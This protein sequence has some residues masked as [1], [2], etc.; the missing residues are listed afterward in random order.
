MRRG[1]A[2]YGLR[3]WPR[4]ATTVWTISPELVL[5]LDEHLG[6]PVDSYVNGSQT[7]LVRRDGPSHARVAAASG[8]RVPRAG[9]GVALRP[10]GGG[11][12]AAL[13]RPPI[14]TRCA[15]ATRCGRSPRCGTGSSATPRT[16]TTSSR[17]SSR[18]RRP[19]SSGAPPDRFGLVDH[20]AIGDAWET[21]ERR[22]CRSSRSCSRS[23]R[24]A[25]PVRRTASRARVGCGARRTRRAA[26]RRRSPG[27]RCRASGARRRAAAA[28]RRARRSRPPTSRAGWP[29][30]SP[31]I[32][33]QWNT[34]E[35]IGTR[36]NPSRRP[37]STA[38]SRDRL[39]LDAGLLEH[40]LHRDLRRRVPDVGPTDRDRA[41][42]PSRRAA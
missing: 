32:I 40:F 9:R 4:V 19:R 18:P 36:A 22:R 42:S 15:S 28:A 10:L 1:C 39:A 37:S 11:R 34:I 29:C 3:R 27:T 25:R 26:P 13:G 21:G 35:Y 2:R 20:D 23:S 7:W 8:R 16:A 5:A 31:P 38:I 14:R 6:L 24:P 30:S 12:R 17:S 33:R 41:T